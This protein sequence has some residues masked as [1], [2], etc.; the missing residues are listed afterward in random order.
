MAGLVFKNIFCVKDYSTG[1]ALA[2][3]EENSL[4]PA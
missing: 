1:R 3:K 2:R 4:K